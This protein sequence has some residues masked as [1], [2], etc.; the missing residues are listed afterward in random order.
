VALLLPG[1][2]ELVV[3]RVRMKTRFA[4]PISWRRMRQQVGAWS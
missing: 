2:G 3:P 1:G 4:L